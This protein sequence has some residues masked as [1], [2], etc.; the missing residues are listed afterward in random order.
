EA[1]GN[2]DE[3]H[4]QIRLKGAVRCRKHIGSPD[5]GKGSWDIAVPAA[6]AHGCRIV[7]D[8]AHE[9]V[10][11]AAGF[12]DGVQGHHRLG[13]PPRRTKEGRN[14]NR[15]VVVVSPGPTLAEVRAPLD[16]LLVKKRKN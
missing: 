12:R 5:I 11:R 4:A 8:G 16:V 7:A 15:R 3:A 13:G 1:V 6:A 10:I 14:G 2:L 9:I